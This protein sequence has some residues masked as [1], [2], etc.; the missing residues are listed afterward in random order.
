[1]QLLIRIHL[2][3][4]HDILNFLKD[5]I[6]MKIITLSPFLIATERHTTRL[7]IG[8]NVIK[9]SGS[10]TYVQALIKNLEIVIH[11]S[12]DSLY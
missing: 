2:Y 11:A 1:M 3:K 9:E 10:R 4:E 7:G 12:A 8:N 6:L 5:S